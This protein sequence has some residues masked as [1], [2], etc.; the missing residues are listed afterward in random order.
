MRN[1]NYHGRRPHHFARI[2]LAV[3]ISP[4]R[5]VSEVEAGLADYT[6]VGLE[7][8]ASAASAAHA[9]R[10]AARYGA[11]SAAAARGAQQYFANPIP[12]STTSS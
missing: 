8:S 1:P 4:K 3:G 6:P 5:A 9:S 11:G 7:A 2:V 10:L 12:S